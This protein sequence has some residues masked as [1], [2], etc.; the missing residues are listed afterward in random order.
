MNDLK[1]IHTNTTLLKPASIATVFTE[2]Y[3]SMKKPHEKATW[4]SRLGYLQLF[5]CGVWIVREWSY[6]VIQ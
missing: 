4:K 5:C 6:K 1:Q 3:R 2:L